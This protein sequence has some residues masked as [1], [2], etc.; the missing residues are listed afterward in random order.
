MYEYTIYGYYYCH[1][2]ELVII[3]FL[4]LTNTFTVAV[5]TTKTALRNV[6]HYHSYGPEAQRSKT[7]SNSYSPTTT[8]YKRDTLKS[9]CM[10]EVAVKKE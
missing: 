1:K 4:K 7:I 5:K 6:W 8:H 10:A 3:S 2:N 9:C